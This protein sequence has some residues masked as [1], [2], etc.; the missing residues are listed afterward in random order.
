M[1][2]VKNLHQTALHATEDPL[3]APPEHRP[4]FP[5]YV[6]GEELRR[7]DARLTRQ[8]AECGKAANRTG[9]EQGSTTALNLHAPHDHPRHDAG[10]EGGG[11]ESWATGPRTHIARRAESA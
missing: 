5:P 2:G 7:L 1:D 6:L 9:S 3:G 11:D 8:V 10:D 4:A